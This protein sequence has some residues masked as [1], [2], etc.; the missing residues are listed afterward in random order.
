MLYQFGDQCFGV[1]RL[2]PRHLNLSA[3]CGQG[4]N[5]LQPNNERSPAEL[6]ARR[7]VNI[8]RPVRSQKPRPHVVAFRPQRVKRKLHVNI[9]NLKPLLEFVIYRCNNE[10]T[11]MAAHS[12]SS[13]KLQRT[14][15]HRY[16]LTFCLNICKFRDC[17]SLARI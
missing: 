11:L 7:Y 5:Q 13:E 17:L 12:Q 15:R 16:P 1:I 14:L 3:R 4:K 10:L 9:V 6:Q 2:I 8:L